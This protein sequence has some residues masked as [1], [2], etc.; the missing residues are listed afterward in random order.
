[1]T[2]KANKPSYIKEAEQNALN[3]C[4]YYS[5]MIALIDGMEYG[6]VSRT[7]DYRFDSSPRQ[8]LRE[9][10]GLIRQA[11]YQEQQNNLARCFLLVGVGGKEAEAYSK[12]EAM[13]AFGGKYSVTELLDEYFRLPSSWRVEDEEGLKKELSEALK[14]EVQ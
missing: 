13:R 3:M 1:M 7:D 8:K 4:K 6:M 10:F 12:K 14:G 9:G 5:D 11:L 2:N